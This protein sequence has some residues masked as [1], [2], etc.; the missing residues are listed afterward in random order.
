VGWGPTQPD[1]AGGSQATAGVG[2]GWALRSLPT[3]AILRF[4]SHSGTLWRQCYCVRTKTFRAANTQQNQNSSHPAS[5]QPQS[6]HKVQWL[7]PA[8]DPAR[9]P[10]EGFSN[11]RLVYKHS[12]PRAYLGTGKCMQK[13]RE[14]MS[15][16]PVSLWDR[17]CCSNSRHSAARHLLP[18]PWGPPTAAHPRVQSLH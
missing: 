8:P 5:A 2:T 12:K 18:C 9:E 10:R 17:G 13:E 3:Q 6:H 11:P 16:H 4:K 15:I 7:L 14:A 1:L